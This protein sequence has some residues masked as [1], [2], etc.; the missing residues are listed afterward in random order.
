M[1]PAGSDAIRKI[2]Q[3]SDQPSRET[4]FGS[5]AGDGIYPHVRISAYP[6]Q[7]WG[8]I[9]IDDTAFIRTR[10]PSGFIYQI[11]IFG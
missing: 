5:E 10:Y 6:Q 2:A 4:E 7:D 9:G 1:D 8:Y 11:E 3:I